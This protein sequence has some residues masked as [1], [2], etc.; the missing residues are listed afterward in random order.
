MTSKEIAEKKGLKI[1]SYLNVSCP[2]CVGSIKDWEPLL[3]EFRKLNVPVILIC[4]TKDSF[5]YIKYLEE[6]R[7]IS[8]PYPLYLDTANLFPA[9]N[10]FYPFHVLDEAVLADA[11]NKI[12]LSGNPRASTEVRNNYLTVIS[13]KLGLNR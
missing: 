10:Q 7:S 8:F 11:D 13:E 12:L 9:N 2:S 5:E 1:F 6:N 3:G 4:H